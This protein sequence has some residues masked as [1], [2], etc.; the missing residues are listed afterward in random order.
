V[1]YLASPDGRD[2][3]LYAKLSASAGV[4]HLLLRTRPAPE[5]MRWE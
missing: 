4:R 3:W 2:V 5:T 1:L